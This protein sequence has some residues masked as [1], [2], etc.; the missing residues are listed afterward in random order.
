MKVVI[1]AG[2]R[3]TRLMDETHGEIPKPLI[4]IGAVPMLEHIMRI[5]AAQGVYE[6]VI[7]GGYLVDKIQSWVDQMRDSLRNLYRI[8]KIEVCN[9]GIE[10]QTGGR[11]KRLA[12]MGVLE[13]ERFMMTYGDGMAD[14][15]IDALLEFHQ[16]QAYSGSQV[17]LTAVRPPARFGEI[18]V[19]DGKVISFSEKTQR[20]GWINGG[21]FVIEPEAINLVNGDMC[22]WEYDVLPVLALQGRIT[23]YQHPGYFQMCDTWRDLQKLE[24]IYGVGA[25]WLRMENNAK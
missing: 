9:T 12:E 10:T 17:T 21:F 18:V 16:E 20:S 23:G 4:T 22:R 15:N 24:A 3:G 2:G 8:E 7:A 11:L 19:L 1:L 14:V 25:P 5:Y 13:F 6:F